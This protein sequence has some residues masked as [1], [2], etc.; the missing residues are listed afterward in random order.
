MNPVQGE[1][2][3]FQ[4]FDAFRLMKGKRPEILSHR[5]AG[6]AGH[7]GTEKGRLAEGIR[8]AAGA[9]CGPCESHVRGEKIIPLPR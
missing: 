4:N 8:R 5:A 3:L 9:F 1:P 7:G 2:F 6:H